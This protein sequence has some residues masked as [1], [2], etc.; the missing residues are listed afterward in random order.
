MDRVPARARRGGLDTTE[1]DYNS[2]GGMGTWA[3]F[4]GFTQIAETIDGDITAESFYE[5]ASNTSE[6]ST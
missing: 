4:V 2:L 6:R 1:L 5:A 3:A